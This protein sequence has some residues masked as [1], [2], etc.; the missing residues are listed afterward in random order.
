MGDVRRACSVRSVMLEEEEEEC[1]EVPRLWREGSAKLTN[2]QGSA[3]RRVVEAW[4]REA[5]DTQMLRSLA[6]ANQS[7]F[8]DLNRTT[9][10]RL[11]GTALQSTALLIY[12]C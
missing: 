4:D 5:L 7:W 12:C 11:N 8:L 9:F 6:V 2:G 3:R 1:Q 10:F